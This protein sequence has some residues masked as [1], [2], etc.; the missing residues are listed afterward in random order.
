MSEQYQTPR[1]RYYA[2]RAARA[3]AGEGPLSYGDFLAREQCRPVIDQDAA[4]RLLLADLAAALAKERRD[5][6]RDADPANG[7]ADSCVTVW[8]LVYE[9]EDHTP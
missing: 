7:D 9:K 6:A 1:Q 8:R 2:E 5:N 4:G 3:A